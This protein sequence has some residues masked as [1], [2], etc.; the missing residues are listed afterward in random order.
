VGRL[1]GPGP[2]LLLVTHVGGGGT[3][4]H[5][6][7]LARALEDENVR[8]LVLRPVQKDRFLLERFASPVTP[9]LVFDLDKEYFT[10]LAVLA[11]LDV[12]HVHIHH[13]LGHRPDLE[14][15]V[16]DLCVPYD[17]TIH[18]YHL[19]CPRI[20]LAGPSGR[21]CGEP[22]QPSAC[23]SCLIKN[24]NYYN[25]RDG[26][27]IGS[28]RD[29]AGA[30]LGGARRV[31]VP[32]ANVAERLSRYFPEV[33][34]TE[35]RHFENL[36]RPRRVVAGRQPGE[37][38]RVVLLGYLAPHKG[39]HLLLGCA[40]DSQRRDLGLQFRLVGFADR[41]SELVKAGVAVTGEYRE[42]DVFDL[43]E[44]QAGHC[45]FFPSL[46]PETYCYTLS[47]ALAAGF[48]AVGFDLGAQGARIRESGW[49]V[50]LPID[51]SPEQINDRLIEIGA[52]LPAAGM[53]PPVEF[54]RYGSILRDYY[55]LGPALGDSSGIAESARQT[56]RVR[57]AA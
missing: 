37:P 5:V 34:F 24:G 9:N 54:A 46:W 15:L 41:A 49:G 57:A 44:D 31:F 22:A 4:R 52:Q 51:S 40:R 3:E 17:W 35:R 55:C 38:L 42:E 26:T 18:D 16:K 27:E 45:T 33:R 7:D 29:K 30:W 47:I 11:N 20:Q 19:I 12:R 25:E 39:F 6:R 43:L 56:R 48:Y 36:I 28:W 14:R 50:V 53:Q 10:L 1:G 23:N 32:H 8:A 13:L 21:Y 2:A